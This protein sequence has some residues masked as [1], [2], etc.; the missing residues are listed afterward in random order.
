MLECVMLMWECVIF[1]YLWMLCVHAYNSSVFSVVQLY[2]AV[3]FLRKLYLRE[4]L[5]LV[6]S[7]RGQ[8]VKTFAKDIIYNA[9]KYFEHQ[10]SKS[11]YREP[12][13]V[14]H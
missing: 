3:G 6:M 10:T 11:K 12:P 7:W 14:M 1:E 5:H 13:Q 2:V 8:K 9:Y 4:L